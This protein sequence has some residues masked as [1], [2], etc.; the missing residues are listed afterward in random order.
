MHRQSLGAAEQDEALRVPE[1]PRTT[2]LASRPLLQCGRLK[3]FEASLARHLISQ[4]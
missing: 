3:W 1:G 2:R 4:Q